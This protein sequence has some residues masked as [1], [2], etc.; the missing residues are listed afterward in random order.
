MNLNL[1]QD[2]FKSINLLHFLKD[3]L[4]NKSSEPPQR[5]KIEVKGVD[6][7]AHIHPQSFQHI[8]DQLIANSEHHAFI[9]PSQRD[10]INF[11]V[12]EDKERKLAII[13]YSNNGTPF[14]LKKDEYIQ[15]FTKSKSSKGSGIGG[16]YIYRIIKAHNGDIE[17]EEAPKSGF[18]MRIEIPTKDEQ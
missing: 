3:K 18:F 11:T 16:N 8:L 10:K 7:S 9:T 13:E 1:N 17:I 2:D 4:S 6:V 14:K 5:Y 12:K 15:F